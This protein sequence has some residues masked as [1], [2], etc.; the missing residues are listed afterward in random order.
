MIPVT[1]GF[2]C[3]DMTL[4]RHYRLVKPVN[5]CTHRETGEVVVPLPVTEKT[6]IPYAKIPYNRRVEVHVGT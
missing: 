2:V 4:G 5:S 6:S 3:D 1:A